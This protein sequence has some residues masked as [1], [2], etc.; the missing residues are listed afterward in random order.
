LIPPG[1]IEGEFYTPTGEPVSDDGER[2]GL[3]SIDQYV[4]G[5]EIALSPEGCQTRFRTN[6]LPYKRFNPYTYSR[7]YR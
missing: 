5:V 3:K 2:Q 6:I 7:R 4:A 1:K